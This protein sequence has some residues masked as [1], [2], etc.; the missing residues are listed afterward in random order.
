MSCTYKFYNPDGI[1]FVSTVVVFWMDVFVRRI[2]KEIFTESLIHCI[3]HKGLVVHAWVLMPSHFH[4]IISRNGEDKL[5][6]IMRD[7]KKFTSPDSYR[8]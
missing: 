4:L 8:D 3:Q 7:F 1:F 6:A 5:E 2:Y